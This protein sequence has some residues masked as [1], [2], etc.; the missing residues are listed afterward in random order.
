MRRKEVAARIWSK[1]VA[2]DKAQGL[3]ARKDRVLSASCMRYLD[4]TLAFCASM[5][6]PPSRFSNDVNTNSSRPR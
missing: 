1:L 3:L 5:T 2:F 4:F 6:R